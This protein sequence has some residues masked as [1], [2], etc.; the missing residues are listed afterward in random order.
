MEKLCNV[1]KE[2]RSYAN[3]ELGIVVAG[4]NLAQ[5]EIMVSL[6]DLEIKI[7]SI[8]KELQYV[9]QEKNK[10]NQELENYQ[11]KLKNLE[12]QS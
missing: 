3:Q 6:Q 9:V 1:L 8:E 7:N 5:S 2:N 4:Q 11:E 12:N 10:I